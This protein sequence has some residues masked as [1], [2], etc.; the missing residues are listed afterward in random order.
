MECLDERPDSGA[1][2]EDLPRGTQIR[3]RVAGEFLTQKVSFIVALRF[4]T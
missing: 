4:F 1:G 2:P 3:H